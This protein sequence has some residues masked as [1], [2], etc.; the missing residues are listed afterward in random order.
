MLAH[1]VAGDVGQAGVEMRVGRVARRAPRGPDRARRRARAS[2]RRGERLTPS[3]WAILPSRRSETKAGVNRLAGRPAARSGRKAPN[4]ARNAS[5]GRTRRISSGLGERRGEEVVAAR[6]PR[7]AVAV[8]AILVDA[9][10]RG[11]ARPSAGVVGL[12][13]VERQDHG[14]GGVVV[15]AG[16]DRVGEPGQVGFEPLGEGLGE[17]ARERRPSRASCRCA[18]AWSASSQAQP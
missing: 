9:R 18:S 3:R 16:A 2:T 1:I 6:L 11:S 7:L 15:G 4:Q 8:L 14:E 10:G 13:P 5:A 17:R 12:R